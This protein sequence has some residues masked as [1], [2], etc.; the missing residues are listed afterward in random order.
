MS[1]TKNI[2]KIIFASTINQIVVMASGFILPPLIISNYGSTIN[3]LV[4]S[5]KQIL[6]YFQVVSVGMGA[7]G[8]VALYEP[9]S[10]NDHK[11]INQIMS[12]LTS[13]LNKMGAVF[14]SLVGII[15]FTLPIV[16]N[17]GIPRHTIIILVLICGA[18]SF[19]EFVLLTK[20]KI[21]LTADQKQYI[22]SRVNT[23][24]TLINVIL[25]VILIRFHASIICVQLVATFAYII[26]ICLMIRTIRKLYPY[27]DLKCKGQKNIKNQTDAL[28][29]KLTDIIINYVP[30]TIVMVICGFKDVSVYSVYNQ[31][32]AAI[33]MMV[34]IFSNGFAAAFGNQIAQNNYEALR[35]SFKGY[36]FIFR[37]IS[38]WLYITAAILV[39]PFISIYITNNDGVNYLLPGL[40][41][42]FSLNGLFRAFRTPS[43]T[44]IDAVGMY[45]E[46][47][48]MNYLEAGLNI[49]LSISLTLKIGIVGVLIGGMISALIR[50]LQFI[51]LINIKI[52]NQSFT[53]EIIFLII[54]LTCG[55]GLYSV[56]SGYTVNSFAEWFIFACVIATTIGFIYLILNVIIDREGFSELFKRIKRLIKQDKKS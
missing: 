51:Y 42:C 55:I 18:G 12:E 11:K 39:L 4:N 38:F 1:R 41:I 36:R 16:R 48:K 15:A 23:Q 53:K 56:F 22:S 9:L 10:K 40:G 45:K 54:N 14:L 6:N 35:Q 47:L 52:I 32:F 43:I 19:I 25:S 7:A 28:L 27:L 30:M 3:G 37:L 13:F 2:I 33:V 49:F 46:N 5:I 17:D 26:R 50:S 44:I 24:G 8:Q 20:Y 21:L 29:Y 34:N 31:V